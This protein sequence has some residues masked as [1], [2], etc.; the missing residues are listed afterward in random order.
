M[1]TIGNNQDPWQMGVLEARVYG[2][3]LKVFR[4]HQDPAMAL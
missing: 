1:D 2:R 4:V 3:F